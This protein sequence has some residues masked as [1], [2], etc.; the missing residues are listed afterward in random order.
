MEVLKQLKKKPNK[1][2]KTKITV[3]KKKSKSLK[4]TKKKIK[5]IGKLYI[6]ITSNNIL[7]TIT[8]KRNKVL[9]I[10]SSGMVGFKKSK[11]SS[12]YAVELTT[13]YVIKKIIQY[14]LYKFYLYF[15]GINRKKRRTCIALLRKAKLFFLKIK[16]NTPIAHGGCRQKKSRRL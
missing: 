15:K 8:D 6:K 2:I 3:E 13:D 7:F 9:S 12:L 5:N 16:D 4:K 1:V 10:I 11:R 14:N